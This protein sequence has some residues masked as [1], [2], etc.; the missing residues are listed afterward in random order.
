MRVSFDE[1]EDIRRPASDDP[2]FARLWG[3][4]GYDDADAVQ[5]TI[6]RWRAQG[7]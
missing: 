1:L 2:S 3:A 7:R 6:A 4:S 5:R